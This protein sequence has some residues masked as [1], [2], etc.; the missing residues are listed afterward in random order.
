MFTGGVKR[1]LC[2][3]EDEQEEEEE[4]E[5]GGCSK[6]TCCEREKERQRVDKAE[7]GVEQVEMELEEDNVRYQ[8][9][10]GAL[11]IVPERATMS[12]D[13]LHG[14]MEGWRLCVEGCW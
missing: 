13:A 7:K 4:R 3:D 14:T 9:E 11:L 1:P 10:G 8:G 12:D 6:R 5:S 2:R